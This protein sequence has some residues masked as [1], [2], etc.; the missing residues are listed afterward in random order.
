MMLYIQKRYSRI[1]QAGVELLGKE[2]GQEY[3]LHQDRGDVQRSKKSQAEVRSSQRAAHWRESAGSRAQ[4]IWG[5]EAANR[6]LLL[7]PRDQCRAQPGPQVKTS[8]WRKLTG[9][10]S[11]LCFLNILGS[12]VPF[13]I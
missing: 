4:N 6:Q 9:S 7:G 1:N 13:R 2:T 5:N 10:E 8:S 11:Q 12:S 3:L